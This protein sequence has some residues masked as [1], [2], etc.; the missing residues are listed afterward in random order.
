MSS[1]FVRRTALA[2]T[3]RQF[4][5]P[6]TITRPFTS[7]L[8]RSSDKHAA[9]GQI[10]DH[11]KHLE[12]QHLDLD[13]PGRLVPFEEVHGEADLLPP[14]AERGTIPTDLE[15][16]TGLERL[17]ILGKMQGVDIFD[18]KPLDASRRGTLDDPIMVRS[19]GDEQYLGCTGYP[20]DSHDVKWLTISRLRPVER[21]I[22]CGGVYKME[23]VGPP[24][25]DSH[26]HH[27]E[28][29]EIRDGKKNFGEKPNFADFLK[30]EYLR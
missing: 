17:E 3:R 5:A 26:G 1:L 21:C 9:S 18:M 7:S 27:D 25:D 6:T 20:A 28:W 13:T 4:V 30:P 2:L 23:Y 19:F 24:D 29:P 10:H 8:F 11:P 14:G 16:A 12:P 22:E 15:Q